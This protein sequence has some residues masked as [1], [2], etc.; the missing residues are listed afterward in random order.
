M[1]V[2]ILSLVL[3]LLLGILVG[4]WATSRWQ[5]LLT[6]ATAGKS[7]LVLNSGARPPAAPGPQRY[8]PVEKV[9]KSLRQSYDEAVVVAMVTETYDDQHH[10]I[11]RTVLDVWKGPA[12]LQGKPMNGRLEPPL[13]YLHS[14]TS[15][16]V[17]TFVALTPWAGGGRSVSFSGDRL[18]MNPALTVAELKAILVEG[19]APDPAL[20]PKL[21]SVP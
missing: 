10:T 16:T 4:P 12:T 2:S 6:P 15:E 17:L 3:G 11:H 21:S 14:K 20:E 7:T 8:M 1:R 5:S 13:S 18:R 19:K 9:V